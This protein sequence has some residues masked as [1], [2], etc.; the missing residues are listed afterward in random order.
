[1]K[2]MQESAIKQYLP[3]FSPLKGTNTNSVNGLEKDFYQEILTKTNPTVLS[4]S[5][6]M[7]TNNIMMLLH[8]FFNS[9]IIFTFNL[10]KTIDI[11]EE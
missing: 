2:L 10:N 1:M 5:Q 7:L 9:S 4:S 6:E 3:F 8:K 11:G